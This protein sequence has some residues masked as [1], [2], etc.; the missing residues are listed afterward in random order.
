MVTLSIQKEL[1]DQKNLINKKGEE[2]T[3]KVTIKINKILEETFKILEEKHG[4]L[5]E[6]VEN[7]EQRIYYLDNM[8]GNVICYFMACKKTKNLTPA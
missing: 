3:Q 7:Q 6:R 5:K 8:Q 1:D 4:N 2:V